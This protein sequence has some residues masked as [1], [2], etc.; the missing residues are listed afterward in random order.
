MREECLDFGGKVVRVNSLR[1]SMAE[2]IETKTRNLEDEIL[3]SS[4]Q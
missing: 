1:A 4:I 2:L 3:L